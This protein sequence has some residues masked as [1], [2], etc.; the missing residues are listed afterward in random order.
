MNTPIHYRT[1]GN[2]EINLLTNCVEEY[3]ISY[4]DD[5]SHRGQELASLKETHEG[6]YGLVMLIRYDHELLNPSSLSALKKTKQ[7]LYENNLYRPII[8]RGIYFMI[9]L[10]GMDVYNRAIGTLVAI[11]LITVP[12][13]DPTTIESIYRDNP[14]LVFCQII[15]LTNF[16]NIFSEEDNET[17]PPV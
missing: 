9:A 16:T 12:D 4:L 5:I 2:P 3:I 6:I 17:T 10:S 13:T 14:W 8:E 15:R 11:H 1:H 7:T